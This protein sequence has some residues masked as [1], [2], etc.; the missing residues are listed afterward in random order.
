MP[1]A[2]QIGPKAGIFGS[3]LLLETA[4]LDEVG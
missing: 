2:F 3:L 1:M 4:D